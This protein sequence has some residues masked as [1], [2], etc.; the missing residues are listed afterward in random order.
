VPSQIT[1]FLNIALAEEAA[2]LAGACE[3]VD[4]AVLDALFDGEPP[5]ITSLTLALSSNTSRIGLRIDFDVHDLDLG[6]MATA[7]LLAKQATQRANFANATFLA[8]DTSLPWTLMIHSSLLTSGIKRQLR[9]G[10]EGNDQL[11]LF[12]GPTATFLIDSQHRPRITTSVEVGAARLRDIVRVRAVRGP[13][14]S[15]RVDLADG[16]A[17]IVTAADAKVSVTTRIP[18]ASRIEIGARQAD[19][20]ALVETGSRDVTICRIGRQATMRR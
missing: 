11:D 2:G 4:I 8:D 6:P 18:A 9:A 10:V 12:D 14:D 5:A 13:G 17:A 3:G 20:V 19:L 15:Y 1:D 7:T 16:T